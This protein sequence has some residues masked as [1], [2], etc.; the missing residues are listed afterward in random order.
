MGEQIR[1]AQRI[2]SPPHMCEIPPS[3]F[4]SI[5]RNVKKNNEIPPKRKQSEAK[6]S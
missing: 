2:L 1:E 4:S 3:F 5:P 6:L